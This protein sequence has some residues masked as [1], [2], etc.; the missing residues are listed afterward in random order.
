M[1]IYEAGKAFNLRYAQNSFRPSMIRARRPMMPNAGI[2][3]FSGSPS[4]TNIT[5]NNGGPSGFWGFMSGFFGGLTGMSGLGNM[6][7]F[8]GLGNMFNCFGGNMFGSGYGNFG[9]LNA[10]SATGAQQTPEQEQAQQLANLKALFPDIAFVAEKDGKFSAAKKDG[11]LIDSKTYDEMKAELGGKQKSTAVK[12]QQGGNPNKVGTSGKEGGEP[13]NDVINT[14][15]ENVD[16]TAVDNVRGSGS[17]TGK[18]A[19]TGDASAPESITITDNS[20][21]NEHKYTYRKLSADEIKNGKAGTAAKD[22]GAY[23]ILESVTDENGNSIKADHDEVYELNATKGE[24]GKYSYALSQD[25]GMAGAGQS[26]IKKASVGGGGSAGATKPRTLDLSNVKNRQDFGDAL[27][28]IIGPASG[29]VF[30]GAWKAYQEGGNEAL[31]EYLKE[32]GFDNVEI[33]GEANI[34]KST[35]S[36]Y[37]W[38]Y[39]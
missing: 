25:E 5:V 35:Q 34:A 29:E 21:G 10:G 12:E 36:R 37:P 11:T 32:K 2:F 22:G 38:Q 23:Y 26:S 6:F 15:D 39:N 19:V 24:S 20:S 31:Q 13:V 16:A 7:G 18:V 30:D 28:K 4:V 1:G 27:M 17:V 9:A 3:G 33:T 14:A 8:C